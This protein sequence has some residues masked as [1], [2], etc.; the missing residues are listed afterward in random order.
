M[1]LTKLALITFLI[2]LIALFF[3][4]QNLEPKQVKISDIN[5]KMMDNYVKLQG[6]VVKIKQ[7]DTLTSLTVSDNTDN[8]TV[9]CPKTNISKD[10]FIEVIGKV[11][12]YNG[13]LEIE[14]ER[15]SEKI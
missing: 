15:I 5:S 9:I 3:L 4:S 7:F 10:S 11:Q 1:H 6:T 2:G 12:E 8:I 14:A 13:I